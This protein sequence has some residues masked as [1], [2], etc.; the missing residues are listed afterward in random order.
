MVEEV[1]KAPQIKGRLHRQAHRAETLQLR[2]VGV[3]VMLVLVIG[4]AMAVMMMAVITMAVMVM[5]VISVMRKAEL[6]LT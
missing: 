1:L 2:G 6:A 3:V 4:V 5:A